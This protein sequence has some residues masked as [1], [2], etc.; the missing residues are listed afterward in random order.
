MREGAFLER[1]FFSDSF[2]GNGNVSFRPLLQAGNGSS[3]I[4]QVSAPSRTGA[5]THTG[6][7][8]RLRAVR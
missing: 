5:R 6:A 2:D 8:I 4:L 7:A 1:G 3:P